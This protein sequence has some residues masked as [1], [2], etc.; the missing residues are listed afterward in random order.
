MDWH[1]LV[2]AQLTVSLLELVGSG[3][4][5]PAGRSVV[6]WNELWVRLRVSRIND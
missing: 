6:V 5:A 3:A 2:Y 4:R 1:R